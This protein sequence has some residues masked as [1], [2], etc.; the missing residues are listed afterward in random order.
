M[1]K[2]IFFIILFGATSVFAGSGSNQYT[3]ICPLTTG[4]SNV[5][6]HYGNYIGGYGEEFM[7]G[8]NI[9]EAYFKGPVFEESN[10][11]H[12]L[13]MGMYVNNGT[14]YASATGVISCM[15]NSTIG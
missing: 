5:L 15:Y 14:S 12:N 11:P 3:F 2:G 7:N 6:T 10:I 4:N 9:P 1:K 13:S 8:S